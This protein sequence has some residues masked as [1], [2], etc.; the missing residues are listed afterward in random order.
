MIGLLPLQESSVTCGSLDCRKL[1]ATMCHTL[2]LEHIFT[3]EN[4]GSWW[5]ESGGQYV[6]NSLVTDAKQLAWA[7]A[8]MENGFNRWWPAADWERWASNSS[9]IVIT[10]TL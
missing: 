8:L 6:D 9:H 3:K 2:E 7:Y 4:I 10:V 1:A 5:E